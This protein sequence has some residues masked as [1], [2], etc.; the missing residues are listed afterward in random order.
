MSKEIPV[1]IMNGMQVRGSSPIPE[2]PEIA[3]PR[4]SGGSILEDYFRWGTCIEWS[5][6]E[7]S[8]YSRINGYVTLDLVGAALFVVHTQGNGIRNRE[9]GYI[10]VSVPEHRP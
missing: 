8:I 10:I 9:L 2:I 7:I 6:H 1:I 3:Y 5:R 4:W